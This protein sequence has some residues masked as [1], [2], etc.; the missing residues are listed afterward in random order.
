MTPDAVTFD[1]EVYALLNEAVKDP[2]SCLFRI[3]SAAASTWIERPIEE[4][5]S[6]SSRSYSAER[7]LLEVYRDETAAVLR[8][9]C[10]KRLMQLFPANKVDT[11]ESLSLQNRTDL[12]LKNSALDPIACRVLTTSRGRAEMS[13]SEIARAG[14]LVEPSFQMRVYYSLFLHEEGQVTTSRRL[15]EHHCRE[16]LSNEQ[17]SYLQSCLG[18][19]Q[20]SLGRYS[21]ALDLYRDSSINN[22]HRFL[23]AAC[24]MTT[25]LLVGERKEAIE[26]ARQINTLGFGGSD[27]ENFVRAL[28][29]SK[30]TVSKG[31]RPRLED[32]DPS[33]MLKIADV[34][35]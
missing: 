20:F 18:Y 35:W 25:A 17:R 7:Y 12:L 33:L 27:L 24:W 5:M 26:A 23:P 10:A 29:R 22:P 16:R 13:G 31:E 2:N 28:S 32:R 1:P 21:I 8:Q 14:L 4:A 6:V 19:V 34:L 15:L 30:P 11:L 9:V 3:P